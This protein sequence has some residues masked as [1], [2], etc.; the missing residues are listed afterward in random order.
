MRRLSLAGALLAAGLAAAGC[1]GRFESFPFITADGTAIEIREKPGAPREREGELAAS[2]NGSGSPLYRLKAP[3]LVRGSSTAF[4][5][6][7][8][9]SL[10]E[11]RLTLYSAEDAVL[12]EASLPE[13]AG[14]TR[15][16]LL[17][18][19][20]GSRIWGYRLRTGSHQG[21]LRLEGAGT[22]PR[23]RGF[24]ITGGVLTSDGSLSVRAPTSRRLSASLSDAA[25]AEMAGE[26]WL[27]S[28]DLGSPVTAGP[29]DSPRVA[30]ILF[31]GQDH[32]TGFSAAPDPARHRF[33]F[34]LGSIGFL[35]RS[36]EVT[37]ED[38]GEQAGPAMRACEIAFI[39]EDVP[40][41]SDPGLILAY[42]RA[43]WRGRD[44]EVFSWD[45]F[46]HV[47]VLDTADYAVQ[48]GMFK[49]LAFFVEKAGYT[50]TIPPVSELEKRHGYNAHDYGAADL[51]R[52]FSAARADRLPLTPGETA[53]L[54]L[55]LANGVLTES[56]SALEPR[57][58]AVLSIS[59]SSPPALRRLLLTH[60]S[61]HGA[62]FSLPEYRDSCVRV[63]DSLSDAEQEVWRLFLSAS[64]YNVQ[65]RNLVINEFQAYLF[66]QDRR[67]VGDFQAIVIERMRKRFPQEAGL[68]DGFL[69]DHPDS[70]LRSFDLLDRALRAAGGPP[71]GSAIGIESP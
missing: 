24:S 14:Y 2:G 19:S 56:G 30:R 39:P 17:P 21:L 18:L 8:S 37:A 53:L 50:G 35:P 23:I 6:T 65:D 16:L 28:V 67:K 22:A 25:R 33:S 61:F 5:L 20:D 13:S 7:Y 52:F 42:E 12:R 44:F 69:R 70:F 3:A 27:V 57:E 45:L 41:P 68:L 1:S 55:L 10:P 66:Q 47:L 26:R 62:Y 63:W 11:C 40:I 36:V 15:R 46:P 71:G 49:R 34:T 32:T 60:E 29:G 59:R 38:A 58:G 64:A 31:K 9:S 51:A 4:S 48:D 43:L 54:K